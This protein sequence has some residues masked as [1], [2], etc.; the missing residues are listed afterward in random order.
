MSDTERLEL[1]SALQIR[2][3]HTL[4]SAPTAYS[5]TRTRAIADEDFWTTVLKDCGFDADAIGASAAQARRELFERSWFKNGAR[6]DSTVLNAVIAELSDVHPAFV[7]DPATVY[8]TKFEDAVERK[9]FIFGRTIASRSFR[10]APFAKDVIALTTGCA[11]RLDLS[12][13]ETRW[14]LPLVRRDGDLIQ[15][16][17][18]SEFFGANADQIWPKVVELVPVAYVPPGADAAAALEQARALARGSFTAFEVIRADAALIHKQYKKL[19]KEKKLAD[20]LASKGDKMLADGGILHTSLPDV[21]PALTAQYRSLVAMQPEIEELR[22]RLADAA[23]ALNYKLVLAPES[24]TYVEDGTG[25]EKNIPLEPGELYRTQQRTITWQTSH[26]EKD[27]YHRR[28]FGRKK[29]HYRTVWTTHERTFTYYEKVEPDYDPWVEAADQYRAEGYQV[30]LLRQ[31][32]EGLTTKDGMALAE[33][34][35]RCRAS[36]AFRRRCIVG[37]PFYEETI[38]G[39]R[40]MIGYRLVFRPTVPLVNELFPILS[41]EEKL[42]YR[43]A[44]EGT[45]LGELVASI[46]LAPGE[47]RQ[48]NVQIA[49]KFTTSRSIK[50]TSLAEITRVDRQDFETLFEAEVRKEKETTTSGGGSVGG[51]YGGFSGSANFSSSTTTKDMSRQLNRSV[52]KASQE[53]TRNNKETVEVSVTEERITDTSSSTS[54]K[55]KNINV[56]R[57]L[58][59][60]LYKVLNDFSSNLVLEDFDFH[61]EAGPYLAELPS[62]RQTRQFSRSNLESLFQ[63]LIEP[64]VLPVDVSADV[65]AFYAAFVKRLALTITAEY[66]E[67]QDG[68]GRQSTVSN[69]VLQVKDLLS[70]NAFFSAS[71]NGE[72]FSI[73]TLP[74]VAGEMLRSDPNDEA[75]IRVLSRSFSTPNMLKEELLNVVFEPTRFSYDAGAFHADAQVGLIPATE[76]FS[77]AMRGLE[78]SGARAQQDLLAARAEYLRARAKAQSGGNGA[79]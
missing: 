60:N 42:S 45:S 44:W 4:K 23:S 79:E 8:S 46:P 41:T 5:F 64:G 49:Q 32:R 57:T 70:R 69:E 2:G 6:G 75:A 13:G 11:L 74:E 34:Y 29:W 61:L 59:I 14:Y 76:E 51:S 3:P 71:D 15:A 43:I 7:H 18:K 53:V 66:K 67:E 47:E 72:A 37:I 77:E 1:P 39:D 36:E 54:F 38:V 21:I 30:F 12:G 24:V 56:G 58:N 33:I 35:E 55:V 65:G 62:F 73:E 25:V 26:Q 50:T 20:A 17:V 9:S 19:D 10:R 28:L 31:D 27:H 68:A 78:E 63:Y 52:A 22:I 16:A 48:V 40:L